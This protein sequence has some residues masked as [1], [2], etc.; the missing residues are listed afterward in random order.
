MS[1]T[2]R[3]ALA[4][5]ER[6]GWLVFPVAPGTK[7]PYGRLV[8]HGHKDATRDR[9]QIR[10]WWDAAPDAGVALACAL[11]GLVVL[12]ADL[13]KPECEFQALERRLATLPETPRQLTPQGGVH[14]LFRDSV[15]SYCNPCQGA[16]AKYDGYILLA[17]SVHPNGGVYRWDVGAHP[18]ETPIAE[19]PDTWLA[20]LTT[21]PKVALPSSGTDA[22]DSWLG[23]A[24][25]AAGWL[26]E[27][28]GDG[29]R[30]ARCPWVHEHSDGRGD[31]SDS[32]TVLFPRAQ[33]RTLGGFRCAHAHCAERS[34]RDVVDALPPKAKWAADQA[35]RQE[36]NRI[37]LEQIEKLR[38]AVGW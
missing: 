12:D 22:A 25:A 37:L 24:F 21:A 3:A 36:R 23:H 14:Y 26:G 6:F 20:H 8:R 29:R 28:L 35:M 34:W 11:S 30:M 10:R 1:A 16:E 19:L 32:S 7:I 33:G 9:D 4:Y 13:Y 2:G 17:P 15:G 18:I 38:K 31:G 5:A 27:A